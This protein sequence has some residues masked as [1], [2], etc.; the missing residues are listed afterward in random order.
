[1]FPAPKT[2]TQSFNT[3][4]LAQAILMAVIALSG[5]VRQRDPKTAYEAAQKTFT[6]GDLADAQKQS[7]KGYQ[8]FRK[9]I[10]I[11]R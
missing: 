8:E 10:L 2:T 9:S 3:I 1:M 4:P 5:C 7:E 11:G 6:H